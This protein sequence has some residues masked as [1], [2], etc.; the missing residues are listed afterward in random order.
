[1]PVLVTVARKGEVG[2]LDHTN[3]HGKCSTDSANVAERG[4]KLLQ[5]GW[6]SL[7]ILS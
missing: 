5:V 4:S 7:G 1:M 2:K 6:G 3:R